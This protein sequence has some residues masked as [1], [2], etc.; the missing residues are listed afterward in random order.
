MA[1]VPDALDLDSGDYPD[2]A[3]IYRSF[4]RLKMCVSGAVTRFRAA[5]PAVWRRP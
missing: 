2:H 1:E 4:D 3:T 5:A